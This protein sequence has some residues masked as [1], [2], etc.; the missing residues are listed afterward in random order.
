MNLLRFLGRGLLASYFVGHGWSVWRH[1]QAAAQDASPVLQSLQRL[2]ARLPSDS[3]GRLMP[4]QPEGFVRLH[5]GLEIAAGLLLATGW[6]RRPAA[7]LLV[8]SQ[9]LRVAAGNPAQRSDRG[10]G[11]VSPELGRDLALLGACLI[12][13]LDTQGRPSLSYRARQHR[14]QLKA[15]RARTAKAAA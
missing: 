5:A 7:L 2:A 13:A 14:S 10:A 6:A 8:G 9:A 4:Q 12:E 15:D 11:L 1:P 3:V